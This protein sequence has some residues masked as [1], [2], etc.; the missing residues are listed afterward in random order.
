ME[1]YHTL[2]LATRK[3]REFNKA[4]GLTYYVA[5]YDDSEYFIV[6]SPTED[7]HVWRRVYTRSQKK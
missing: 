3:A 7:M 1:T 4:T 6:M 2:A 5:C